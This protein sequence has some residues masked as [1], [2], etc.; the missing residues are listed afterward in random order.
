MEDRWVKICSFLWRRVPFPG[1]RILLQVSQPKV[2]DPY[3]EKSNFDKENKEVHEE[4]K[5]N[6]KDNKKRGDDINQENEIFTSHNVIEKY[7]LDIMI[8]F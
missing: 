1:S 4:S 7:Q 8:M 2:Q 5:M 3:V 6:T